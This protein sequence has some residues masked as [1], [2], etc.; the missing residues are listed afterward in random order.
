MSNKKNKIAD[1]QGTDFYG[2]AHVPTL[3]SPTNGKINKGETENIRVQ[4]LI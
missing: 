4:D 1:L 2:N 3:S